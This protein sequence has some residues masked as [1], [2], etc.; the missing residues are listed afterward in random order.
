MNQAG[1]RLLRFIPARGSRCHC[2]PRLR[3]VG[4]PSRPSRPPR[5]ASV[6]GPDAEGG[7]RGRRGSCDAAEGGVIPGRRGGWAGRGGWL[8]SLYA[9]AVEGRG[10]GRC[11][12]RQRFCRC[13]LI[14]SGQFCVV[15]AG[16]PPAAA[17][18][19]SPPLW[20]PGPLE[21]PSW[22]APWDSPLRQPS[23]TAAAAER[24]D[25]QR[26]W[27]PAGRKGGTGARGR[28]ARAGCSSHH[29]RPRRDRCTPC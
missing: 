14:L 21:Q 27:P 20:P 23:G 2:R 25:R 3:R 17:A 12:R 18:A 1:A 24:Q 28:V 9:R 16:R 11:F 6:G 10:G 26:R 4:G 22:T 13:A 19:G 5:G 7:A 15:A 29:G 8:A